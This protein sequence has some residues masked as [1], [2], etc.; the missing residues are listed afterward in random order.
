MVYEFR[1]QKS[2]LNKEEDPSS[3]LSKKVRIQQSL[4]EKKE[5]N[6]GLDAMYWNCE[7]NLLKI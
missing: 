3:L 5:T 1:K 6:M 4:K 7:T 2:L